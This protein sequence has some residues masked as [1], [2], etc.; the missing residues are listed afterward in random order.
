MTTRFQRFTTAGLPGTLSALLALVPVAHAALREWDG[1]A[2]MDNKWTTP[3]NWAGNVAP[4]PGDDLL[5]RSGARHPNNNNDFAPGTT[6][7]SIELR[8][9][10]GSG[11][12]LGG[13]S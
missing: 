5:F 1:D 2:S 6:F 8:G 11:Y 4:N 12:N 3:A 9:G 7:N 10:G 13:N